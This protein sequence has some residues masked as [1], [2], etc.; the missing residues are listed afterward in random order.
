MIIAQEKRKENIAEYLLYMFQIED[1]IR[2]SEFNIDLIDQR[3][4]SRFDQPYSV[5]RDMREWYVSLIRMMKDNG[6]E[7]K[8]H[9]PLLN[10]L[11]DEVNNL[12]L[13]LLNK[14]N[15]TNYSDAF[16]NARP[17]IEELRV[18]SQDASINDVELGLNGLYGLLM[19]RL[20]QRTLNPE[21]EK[22]FGHISEWL[23]ELSVRFRDFEQGM[24]EF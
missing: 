7:K 12:H 22:A 16:A 2:A 20:Q 3:I 19:L 18:K 9:I 11:I 15:E 14:G 1:V 5:K 17:A 6:V 24:S 13:R 4:I 23:A 8:G 10:S 21:T